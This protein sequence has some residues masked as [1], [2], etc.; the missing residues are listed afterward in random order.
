[1]SFKNFAFKA[2][3]NA[4]Y[5]SGSHKV[6]RPLSGGLGSILMFHHVREAPNRDFAPNAHLTVSPKFLE[7]TLK[8]LRS[9]N[10]DIVSMD[11]AILRI[12]NGQTNKPFVAITFDDGYRD[13]AE[14][15]A[16]ILR[17]YNAPY[18]IYIA[19][20]LIDGS[21]NLW[22]DGLEA[23]IRNQDKILV[24][25]QAGAGEIECST[26]KA[27]RK[28]YALLLEYLTNDLSEELQREWI[29]EYAAHYNVDLNS[30]LQ[31][32]MMSWD[33]IKT[34]AEDPL[35][36]IGTHTVHHYA[37]ARLEKE[38]AVAEISDGAQILEAAL[39]EKPKHFAYPYGYSLA[40]GRRDFEIVA[41]LGFASAVTTRP[42]I[43]YKDHQPHM[44]ALPRISMNGHFQK[45]R[46]TKVLLS[47]S[48]TFL[49]NKMRRL[50]VK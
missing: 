29:N 14:I 35:C 17:K 5:F 6:L 3:M 4:L 10:I 27:K 33:E 38:Q 26:P 8:S 28:T 40:A 23:I 42:G 31:S 44:T 36:T 20:G 34:L 32:E 39:G 45:T 47:G 37:L 48:P 12:Q 22:W 25:S 13:N 49:A 7:A 16:P 18:T 9:S 19:S 46:Y 15:A 43:I 21:A 30:M 41:E 2:V 24:R 50:N 11:E 1:M